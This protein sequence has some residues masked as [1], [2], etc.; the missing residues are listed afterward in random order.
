[1]KLLIEE[2]PY[3]T[4]LVRG[5]LKGLF[6]SVELD[7]PRVS[8]NYVGYFFNRE[9]NDCVFILPKVIIDGEG[10]VFREFCPEDLINFEKAK[11]YAEKRRFLQEFFVWIYRAISVYEKANPES[12]I[13]LKKDHASVGRGRIGRSHTLFDVILALLDFNREHRDF[14]TFILKDRRRGLNKINWTRTITSSQAI[15]QDE[16]PVYLDPV[17]RKRFVNFDEELFVIYFSILR[18]VHETYGFQISVLPGFEL[19]TGDSFKRYLNG[20]GSLRLKQIKYK[21]FSDV[22]L[23]LWE[24]CATFFD[25][26]RTVRSSMSSEYLLAKNF[27]IVFE[28]MIDELIGDK[29]IPKDL[30]EQ[31]DGKRVDHLYRDKGLIENDPTYYIGD[32]KYYKLSAGGYKLGD[33]AVYKQYTYARN[34]VQYNLDLFLDE[35]RADEQMREPVKSLRDDVTEG[36]NIVPNFFISA[37]IDNATLTYGER[38]VECGSGGRG[39]MSRQF[40]N[41]LFDRDTLLLS[42]FNVNFLHV[43]SL[44]A[45]NNSAQKAKW[46]AKVRAKFRGAVQERLKRRYGFWAMRAK[47]GVDG[48]EYFKANFQKV[49]GKV[50]MPFGADFPGVYSLALENDVKYASGNEALL[51]EL[52]EF[53]DVAECEL[54]RS[55]DEVLP[56]RGRVVAVAR[57]AEDLVLC[58]TREAKNFDDTVEK[59]E[60]SGELGVALNLTG[61]TLHLAEGFT[62]TRYLLVHNKGDRQALYFTDGKGPRFVSGDDMGDRAV[63]KK[64]AGMYLVFGVDRERR[65]AIDKLDLKAIT[66]RGPE[67]Y[68]PQFV[69]LKDLGF[70]ATG[71]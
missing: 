53:F 20:Y 68:L 64:G 71:K 34:V 19:I 14:V 31:A 45:R 69:A 47:P 3:D 29:D 60:S 9:I 2:Y 8:I 5:L 41:R 25:L 38:L 54:G 50:F 62:R 58:V 65:P 52:R 21:Y 42:H 61:A 57:G 4:N 55:P 22:A 43:L 24:L 39:Y 26:A 12:A 35:T 6:D 33:E 28:A 59:L 17:N 37:N 16:E 36:Y 1:M 66:S 15:V 23:R 44:Y 30:K 51:G 27:N 56:E 46:R 48:A 70:A 67:S 10:K 63:T 13:I 49:L 18:H 40:D 7:R 11:Q 32:S